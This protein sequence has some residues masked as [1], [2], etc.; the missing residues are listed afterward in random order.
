MSRSKSSAGDRPSHHSDSDFELS[1]FMPSK[2]NPRVL[3]DSQHRPH[4]GKVWALP[5][6]RATC[7][8]SV[9]VAL[10]EWAG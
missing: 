4:P 2:C 8:W 5:W 10:L 6:P 9:P 1:Y 3:A 7:S